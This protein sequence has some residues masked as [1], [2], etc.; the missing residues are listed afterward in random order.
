MNLTTRIGYDWI[1][2]NQSST[3]FQIATDFTSKNRVKLQLCSSVQERFLVNLT[4]PGARARVEVDLVFASSSNTSTWGDESVENT[5]FGDYSNL[6]F[7][8]TKELNSSRAYPFSAR[9][10]LSDSASALMLPKSDANRTAAVLKIKGYSAFFTAG[11]YFDCLNLS[12]TFNNSDLRRGD[13]NFNE[14]LTLVKGGIA[15]A[16]YFQNINLAQN[17]NSPVSRF[18]LM[19]DTVPPAFVNCPNSV[20]TASSDIGKNTSTTVSIPVITA[21]DNIAVA[22]LISDTPAN[23]IFPINYY[24][25]PNTTVTYVATDTFGNS[26]NCSFTVIVHDTEPPVVQCPAPESTTYAVDLNSDSRSF[27]NVQAGPQFTSVSDNHLINISSFQIS[28]LSFPLGTSEANLSI[29]DV[30]GNT[31]YCT[32]TVTVLSGSDLSSSSASSASSS[33]NLTTVGGVVGGVAAGLILLIIAIYRRVTRKKPHNFDELMRQLE[34]VSGMYASGQAGPI[35][36]REIRR[37]C[38]K[39]IDKLGAGNFGEVCKGEYMSFSL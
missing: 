16:Y 13:I 1:L 6:T 4:Q 21:T 30:S 3:P 14:P 25:L 8:G 19:T 33:V 32:I 35:K 7:A 5:V 2:H 20:I 27:S 29:S 38:V 26:N 9:F 17:A 24:Q 36:P 15:F 28:T 18:A 22:S 10:Y 39:I 12:L 11:F 37:H 34:E 31:A 23:S